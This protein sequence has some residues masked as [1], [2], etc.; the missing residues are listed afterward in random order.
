MARITNLQSVQEDIV[1]E[2]LTEYVCTYYNVKVSV[3]F[4]WKL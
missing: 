4:C 3:R 2:N 1:A